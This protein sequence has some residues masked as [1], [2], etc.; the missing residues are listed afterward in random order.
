MI[1]LNTLKKLLISGQ[2]SR[3]KTK[4]ANTLPASHPLPYCSFIPAMLIMVLRLVLDVL[5]KLLIW[6]KRG[7]E[8]W[9]ESCLRELLQEK[10]KRENFQCGCLE[11]ERGADSEGNFQ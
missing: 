10:M 8:G 6:Q 4:K 1:Y 7:G 5:T 11:D 3:E 2:P 9:G